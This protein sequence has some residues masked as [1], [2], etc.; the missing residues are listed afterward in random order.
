[1][2]VQTYYLLLDKHIKKEEIHKITTEYNFEK[3][4]ERGKEHIYSWKGPEYVST[5]GCYFSFT[6]DVNLSDDANKTDIYKTLCATSTVRGC[7]YADRDKQIN[8]MKAIRDLYGGKIYDPNQ[9]TWG[10]RENEIP[11]LSKTEIACGIQ[12]VY[13][14]VDLSNKANNSLIKEVDTREIWFDVSLNRYEYPQSLVDNNKTVVLLITIFETFLKSFFR[15]YLETN[16]DAY[17]NFIVDYKPKEEISNEEDIFEAHLRKYTFQN[18]DSANKAY[19]KYLNF[20]LKQEVLNIEIIPTKKD[21]KIGF[22]L[23]QLL[24]IRH[25]KIH[26]DIYSLDL[27]KEK[28]IQYRNLIRIFGE[29][30]IGKFMKNHNLK[31]L[32]ER[33]LEY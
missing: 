13:F 30:F 33:E 6:Y 24:S 31:L 23:T 22:L 7:S 8:I 10:I 29:N 16:K 17:Q 26:E 4:D 11:Q 12:Y 15:K 14:C 18:L 28:T 2:S 32:I 20:N 9:N 21:T 3:I 1:M 25:K 27:T 5:R 19:K